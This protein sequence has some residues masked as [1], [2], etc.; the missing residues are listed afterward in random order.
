[1]NERESGLL[2]EREIELCASYYHMGICNGIKK[3]YEIIKKNM[4]HFLNDLLYNNTEID[5]YCS[6]ERDE[7]KEKLKK[8][9]LV[10]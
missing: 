8:F 9:N 10:K 6:M 3:A 5:I 7:L 4:D 1:M 2:T